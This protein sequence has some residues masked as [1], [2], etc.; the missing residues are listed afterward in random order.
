M[1]TVTLRSAVP[2]EAEPREPDQPAWWAQAWLWTVTRPAILRQWR[3][4]WGH[5]HECL[6]PCRARH[7]RHNVA[8]S[9]GQRREGD[10]TTQALEAT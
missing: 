3:S 6:T 10:D 2:P 4:D 7:C 1:A 9:T 8:G 5:W